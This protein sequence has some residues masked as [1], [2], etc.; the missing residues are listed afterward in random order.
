MHPATPGLIIQSLL[1]ATI[2]SLVVRCRTS[3]V[4]KD[5]LS[6]TITSWLGAHVGTGVAIYIVEAASIGGIRATALLAIGG[7]AGNALSF[8]L[9][10]L[11]SS[12]SQ[13]RRR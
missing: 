12:L 6:L 8:Y 7:I 1:V 9:T 5:A 2:I 11:E 4:G 10:A 3:A 13:S